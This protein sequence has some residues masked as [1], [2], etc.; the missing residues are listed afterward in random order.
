MVQHGWIVPVQHQTRCRSLLLLLTMEKNTELSSLIIKQ[1]QLLQQQQL[2]QRPQQ[3]QLQQQAQQP[4]QQPQ[5]PAAAAVSPAAVGAAADPQRLSILGV[6]PSVY[7][8]TAQLLQ[9]LLSGQPNQPAS[10]SMSMNNS[11]APLSFPSAAS[12]PAAAFDSGYSPSG[13]PLC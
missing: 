4:Q 9:R 8:D 12:V 6:S 10:V 1:Q 13:L 7:D 5:Q 3:Q 11:L 2:Q